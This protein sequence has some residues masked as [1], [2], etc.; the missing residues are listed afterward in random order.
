MNNIFK[1]NIK[2]AELFGTASNLNNFSI[3][4]NNEVYA[5]WS[6]NT[7]I[8]T[9]NLYFASNVNLNGANGLWLKIKD[10]DLSDT[11]LYGLNSNETLSGNLNLMIENCIMKNASFGGSYNSTINND[12]NIKLKNVTC[13][14]AF[15]GTNT[16]VLGNFNFEF[17]DLTIEKTKYFYIGPFFKPGS[18]NI[19]YNVND[20]NVKLNS[21][22]IKANFTPGLCV[23]NSSRANITVNAGNINVILNGGQTYLNDDSNSFFCG[24]NLLKNKVSSFVANYN[25]I[26]VIINGG[27]WFDS[28][29]LING[30]GIFAGPVCGKG[31]A[32]IN[33]VYM[34]LNG[35]NVSTLFGGG[36]PQ[37]SFI[38]N[39]LNDVNIVINNGTIG[40]IL[41]MST[42]STSTDNDIG[43][44]HTFGNVYIHI[45]GGNILSLVHPGVRHRNKI[46]SN[47]EM[48]DGE[49][50]VIISGNTNYSCN[51]Q[52]NVLHEE[53][54]ST[55][56]CHLIFENYNGS[57]HNG[58]EIIGFK[59]IQFRKN[60]SVNF[61]VTF[62]NNTNTW[63]IDLSRRD[64]DYNNIPIINFINSLSNLSGFNIELILSESNVLTDYLIISDEDSTILN[65]FSNK[66]I[67]VKYNDETIYTGSMFSSNT[68]F[69]ISN[70]DS[71]FNNYGFIT[72]ESS[73][74]FGKKV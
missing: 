71:I 47:Q 32:N 21:G 29:N 72:D 3:R 70:Q 16:D 14:G 4:N 28:V 18:A 56:D 36:Y 58:A 51:F 5:Y 31:T 17:T 7:I 38:V 8:P 35:G 1:N 73:I 59:D 24:G 65:N 64:V 25:S 19:T 34:E 57:I 63:T 20:I 27:K 44:N 11:V 50:Y 48:L 41:G 49:G 62:T 26:N 69:T 23:N 10:H 67:Q 46:D 39:I 22:I 33:N 61:D 30:V 53:T 54:T 15:M 74:R 2:E 66:T 60:T 45:N 9:G 52:G 12:L 68:P 43:T 40:N 13:T 6:K 42:I 37:S 55:P